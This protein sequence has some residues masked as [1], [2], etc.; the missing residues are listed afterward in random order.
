MLL[1]TVDFPVLYNVAYF[2]Y[3]L[4]CILLLIQCISDIT[5]GFCMRASFF[6]YFELPVTHDFYVL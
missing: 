6:P 4:S 2:M 3:T 1:F 5:D